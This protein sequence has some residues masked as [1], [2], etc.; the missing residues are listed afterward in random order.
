MLLAFPIARIFRFSNKM[1][2]SLI[3]IIPFA[4]IAY[5]GIPILQ[6]AFGEKILPAA[7]IISAVYIFWLFTLGI[8]LIEALDDSNINIKTGNKAC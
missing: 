1:R 2:R 3:L 6:N 8:I 4:N 5:L 7:A